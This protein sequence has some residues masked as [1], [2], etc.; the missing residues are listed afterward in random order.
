MHYSLINDSFCI[1]HG[2]Y[3]SHTMFNPFSDDSRGCAPCSGRAQVVRRCAQSCAGVY[4]QP[5]VV[6]NPFNTCASDFVDVLIVRMP[7]LPVVIVFWHYTHCLTIVQGVRR[8][9]QLCACGLQLPQVVRISFNTCAS[10]F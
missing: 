9:A 6:R 1:V 7:F 5:Q 2:S 8:R 3:F 10:D 4:Q